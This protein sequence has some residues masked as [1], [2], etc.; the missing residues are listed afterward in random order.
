MD[1]RELLQRWREGDRAA[2]NELFERHFT[3]VC[4]FFRNKVSDGVDDLIQ[5]T[6]VTCLEVEGGFRGES[7]FRSYLMGIARNVLLR[8]FREKSRDGRRFA[9]LEDSVCDVDPSPSMLVAGREEHAQLFEALR[10][11]PLDLQIALEL[12]F[13]ESWTMREI[14]AALEVPPGTAASRLRRGKAALKELLATGDR[15]EPTDDDLMA[16]AV[17][18]RATL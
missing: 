12:Y 3:A 13:W 16:W 6:F 8:S 4:N 2:G 5:R 11:L 14:A 15:A 10:K 17:K 9:P 7:S 1:D 18:V